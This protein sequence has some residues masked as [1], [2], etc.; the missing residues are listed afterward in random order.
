MNK[1]KPPATAIGISTADDVFVRGKSLCRDIIG[2]F[3]FTEMLFFQI[4]GRRPSAAETRVVDACLVTLLE[5]G[6]TPSVIATRLVYTSAPEAMQGAVAAGLL[7][8]GSLFVGTTEGCGRLLQRLVEAAAGGG[9]LNAHARRIADEHRQER[10]PV[11]GFGH[12]QHKPDDPRSIRLL[13]LARAEGIAGAHVAAVEALG[14]AV[15]AASGRHIT[16]NATGA[17][18]ALLGDCGVPADILRGFA[19]IARCAGL[20][21]HIREEQQDPAMF[22]LWEAGARAVPYTTAPGQG[23]EVVSDRQ[24][25]S[26]TEEEEP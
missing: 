1:E 19:I 18:A 17:V 11:P 7:A 20:V 21:G 10:R 24:P 14:R 23:S 8:V 15:D 26:P 2:H 4:L 9:D 22:A 5:H 6:L 16:L 12:P 13:A 25:S 3:T